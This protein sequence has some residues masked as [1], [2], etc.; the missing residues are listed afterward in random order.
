VLRV[1]QHPEQRGTLVKHA[2]IA[3]LRTAK[4][5]RAQMKKKRRKS[6]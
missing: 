3:L 5:W 1:L 4:V 2:R 6:S